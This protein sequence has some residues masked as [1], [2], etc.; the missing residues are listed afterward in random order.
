[1]QFTKIKP[2][3]WNLSFNT[4]Y[5]CTFFRPCTSNDV[6]YFSFIL[7]DL[8]LYMC[9]ACIPHYKHGWES[10]K[11]PSQKMGI[12]GNRKEL[13]QIDVKVAINEIPLTQIPG[14]A[15]RLNLADNRL[16]IYDQSRLPITDVLSVLSFTD[17]DNRY[18]RNCRYI[19][20]KTPNYNQ[21]LE[22]IF[23]QSR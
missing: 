17:T 13:P 12:H 22:P 7:T 14:M 8:A 6:Q 21:Y 5:T 3:H 20:K 9:T 23:G 2:T 16:P 15:Y 19:G 18:F 11:I 1:M 10:R 4:T